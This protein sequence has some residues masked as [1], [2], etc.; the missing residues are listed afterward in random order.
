MGKKNQ[1]CC[2]FV[3]VE[4][5]SHVSQ[6]ACKPELYLGVLVPHP[7][8]WGYRCEPYLVCVLSPEKA[9]MC[10]EQILLQLNHIPSSQARNF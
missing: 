9:P 3:Y 2:L 10:V 5:G 7:E 1:T 4:T 8:C 6:G